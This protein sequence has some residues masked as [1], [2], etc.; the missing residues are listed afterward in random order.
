VGTANVESIIRANSLD[1]MTSPAASV[2]WNNQGITQLASVS[3][4]DGTSADGQ[5]IAQLN[6]PII[7]GFAASGDSNHTFKLGMVSSN[8]T[9]AFGV[10]GSTATDVI[11]SR[12]G[13]ALL[14]VAANQTTFP[15]ASGSSTLE[16]SPQSG[17][18]TSSTPSPLI[19]AWSGTYTANASSFNF[20]TVIGFGPT[21]T[22][23]QSGFAFG[24]GLLFNVNPV[25]KTGTSVGTGFSFGP[26]TG[27]SYVPTFTVDTQ[28]GITALGT[29]TALSSN[30]VWSQAN[31]G[32]AT[33]AS[34]VGFLTQG[35]VGTGITMTLFNDVKV[36]D[37]AGSGTIT[38]RAAL[39]IA[40]LTK[41][42]TNL[43]IRNAST[44]VF[45]HKVKTITATS[46]S[47]SVASTTAATM[48][49]LNNTSGS[50]KTLASTPTITA[51]TDGQLL[52]LENTS[53]QNVVFQ[54]ESALAGSTL[55]LNAA[56]VTLSQYQTMLLIWDAV[57][58]QWVQ[59]GS[60]AN[61]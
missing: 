50:S 44:T 24:V 13:T 47:I 53:A 39:D 17:T 41:A 61:A 21:V 37:T 48:I 7:L 33:V 31:S 46:D 51:G 27:L 14:K 23:S 29:S 57:N 34:H 25:F 40:N 58:T 32:T 59:L 11:L 16:L 30:P 49:T 55:R 43:G 20:G 3:M 35:N 9:L 15:G 42:T 8:P 36:L 12:T 5:I 1:Q 6:P 18:I 22:F 2:N 19:N 28:T 56:T 4:T 45:T 60:S 38:T 54:R 10:G 52:I 26:L